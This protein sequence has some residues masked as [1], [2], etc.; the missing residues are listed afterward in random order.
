VTQSTQASR[1]FGQLLDPNVGE[2]DA[3]GLLHELQPNR[4]TANTILELCEHAYELAVKPTISFDHVSIFGTG[5]DRYKTTNIS[6]LASLF[7]SQLVPV[8]KVGTSAVTARWGSSDFFS[9][10]SRWAPS[11]QFKPP[12]C[13]VFLADIGFPYS[14]ALRRARVRL[15]DNGTLDICKI[16]FPFT[17]FSGAR[18]QVTGASSRDYLDILA[19]CYRLA[20]H[21]GYLVH[22]EHGCD[23]LLPGRNVIARISKGQISYAPIDL[24]YLSIDSLAE[25]STLEM[26]VSRAIHDLRHPDSVLSQVVRWNV[27]VVHMAYRGDLNFLEVLDD[28]REAIE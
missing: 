24:P 11:L 19:E 6:S 12:S 28:T 23:E 7:A 14:P 27:A 21:E 1:S 15:F 22:S 18:V 3:Y 16:V 2:A 25:A 4:L 17:N 26:Q 5:G 10:L 9:G 20:G 13:T 8:V